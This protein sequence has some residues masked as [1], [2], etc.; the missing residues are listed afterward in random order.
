VRVEPGD[1]WD[2][3]ILSLI[4]KVGCLVDHYA[5]AQAYDYSKVEAGFPSGS[6]DMY[7][8]EKKLFCSF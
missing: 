2:P 7:G 3:K 8:T 1:F 4:G 6:C 5:G